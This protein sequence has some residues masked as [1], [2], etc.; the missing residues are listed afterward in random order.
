MKKQSVL[1]SVEK[2]IVVGARSSLLSR[3]QV[4]E[5]LLELRQFHFG[6]SFRSVFLQTT[7]DKDLKTSLRNLDKSDFFTKEIDAMQ[8]RGECRIAIHSAK[9]LPSPLPD[10]LSLIA[11]TKGIDA[12]DS[13]VFRDGESLSDLPKFAKIGSSTARR[14]IAVREVLPDA[15]CVDIRSTIENRLAQLDAGNYDAIVVAEAA[16]IRLNL[17][18]R[19]RVFLPGETTPLQGRLAV[20]AKAN[21]EEMKQLFLCIH[22]S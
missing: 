11:L 9:D 14:D 15:I 10:G 6:I 20:I 21:D 17:T 16:L 7:G 22:A 13:L 12:S 4:E 5:V 8:L 2:T 3:H 1:S 18:H 19:S